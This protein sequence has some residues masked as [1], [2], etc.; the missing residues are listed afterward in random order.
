[1]TTDWTIDVR[2]PTEAKDFSSSLCIQTSSEAHPV[3]CTMGT[4]GPFPW[5]KARKGRDADHSPFLVPRSRMSRSYTSSL[6]WRLH[7]GRGTAL[8]FTFTTGRNFEVCQTS[9]LKNHYFVNFY[10]PLCKD[11]K[12]KHF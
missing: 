7:G 2:S 9:E 5:G 3:S 4:G 11:L 8:D 6:L 1:M 12:L 10:K